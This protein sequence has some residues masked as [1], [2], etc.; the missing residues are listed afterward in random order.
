MT[1]AATLWIIGIACLIVALLGKAI[2]IRDFE[3]PEAAGKKVRAG[4]AV[5]GVLALVLGTALFTRPNGDQ[6][7]PQAA[8]SN[9]ADTPGFSASPPE[10]SAGT[11]QPAASASAS[12]PATSPP[13]P[14]AAPVRK[15]FYLDTLTPVTDGE[16]APEPGSWQ[17]G[18]RTYPHSLKYAAD[19]PQVDNV[20]YFSATYRIPGSY[21]YLVATVGIPDTPGGQGSAVNFQVSDGVGESLGT[22][23]AQYGQPEQIRVPVQGLSTL[24]LG[25]SSPQTCAQ[26]SGWEAVWGNAELIP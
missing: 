8:P 6:Q 22:Q 17:L 7:L 3:L 10:P 21:Q 20:C 1:D 11:S 13:A 2:R 14:P 9:G 18:T 19:N 12:V 4:M 23:S 15:P 25:T 26:G 16:P 24:T 5:V